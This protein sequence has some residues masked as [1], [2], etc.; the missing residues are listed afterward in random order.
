MCLTSTHTCTALRKVFQLENM[1][2]IVFEMKV[3]VLSRNTDINGQK[4]HCHIT[5][6]VNIGGTQC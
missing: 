5:Y 3:N 2:V 4:T 1:V 6:N